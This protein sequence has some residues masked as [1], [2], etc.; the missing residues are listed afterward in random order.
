MNK[1]NFL[2]GKNI[3]IT[4]ASSGIGRTLTKNL[5]KF[6]ANIIMLSKNEKKLDAIY[7]E[8][9][10]PC[11][12]KCNLIDLD[13]NKSKEIANVILENYKNLDAIIHNAAILEKISNIENYDVKTW[14]KVLKVNLTSSFILSKYLIPLMSSS[15][16]PRII[17][18]TSSVGKKGKAYWG[19]YSV[20][21][22]GINALSQILS[23][24]LE[25]ISSIKVFN[26]DPKGTQTAMRSLAYPA[27]DP[28]SQKKPDSLIEY[29]L[30][31]L[32][33]DSSSS[34]DRYI[35]FGQKIKTK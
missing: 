32:S 6:G 12:L 20:S 17:F 5:S 8:I 29:Y 19:A 3:L 22:A 21:K 35:E 31:M 24:E 7:D 9:K 11:I 33:E 23:D 13:E 30:W 25:T 27:E 1:N 15:L 2:Q 34:K 26:F 16:N 10:D 4:G 14:E 18:T 28:D